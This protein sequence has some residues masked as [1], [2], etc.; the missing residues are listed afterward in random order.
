L[1]A[2]AADGGWDG[3]EEE[4]QYPDYDGEI[5][6][7]GPFRP[8]SLMVLKIHRDLES[9]LGPGFLR[10]LYDFRIL[11]GTNGLVRLVD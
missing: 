2:A 9:S 11:S 1:R 7:P 6:G 10:Y 8:M 3:S 5:K 4:T